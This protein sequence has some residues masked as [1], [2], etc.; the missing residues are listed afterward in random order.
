MVLI[1][2]SLLKN[3]LIINEKLDKKI[4]SN[5]QGIFLLN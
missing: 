5:E 4:P 1:L 3:K 2:R